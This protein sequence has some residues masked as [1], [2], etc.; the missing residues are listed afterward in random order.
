[1]KT[2]GRNDPCPCG[3][4]KKYK[5]CCLHQ[6]ETQTTS[7]WSGAIPKAF[8]W[9]MAKHPKPL[10]QALADG[11]FGSLD[12]SDYERLQNHEA[13][14]GIMVHAFEWLLA[15]GIIPVQGKKF[16]VPELL[17]G[18]GGPFFSAQQRQWIQGLAAS[19]LRPYEVLE[20][21][22]G[23]SMSLKDVLLPERSPVL[24]REKIGSEGLVKFDLIAARVVPI[25]DHF[26]L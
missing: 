3:S 25:D 2:L 8:S 26:V 11:F 9:L 23:T 17:L 14:R 20:V 12:K 24:V 19:C 7:D 10:P 18:R 22:P 16:R 6:E 13:F 21:T 15:E 1:M 4:G 5:H